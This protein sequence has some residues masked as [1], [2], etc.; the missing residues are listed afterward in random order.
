MV[1]TQQHLFLYGITYYVEAMKMIRSC[2][3]E[4]LPSR[5]KV[6]VTMKSCMAE[7]KS[8]NAD[9]DTCR[10]GKHYS[11]IEEDMVAAKLHADDMTNKVSFLSLIPL[12]GISV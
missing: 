5:G 9:S 1:N 3:T 4:G 2:K 11:R 8:C 12:N 10:G 6:M 7:N